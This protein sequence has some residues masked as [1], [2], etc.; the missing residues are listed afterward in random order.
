MSYY[1][2]IEQQIKNIFANIDIIEIKIPSCAPADILTGVTD[3]LLYKKLLK[4]EDGPSFKKKEAF[5]L[6]CS[7]DGMS[8]CKKSKLT[9]WPF[10]FTCNELPIS[11]RFAFS[12]LI[13]GGM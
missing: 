3:G 7:A 11:K 5:S 1:L 12:N 8:I 2:D 6:I 9:C 4:T 13:L 10:Y